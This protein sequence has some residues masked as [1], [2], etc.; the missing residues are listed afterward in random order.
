MFQV[1]GVHLPDLSSVVSE[2]NEAQEIRNAI[3]HRHGVI[4]DDDVVRVPSLVPTDGSRVRI[5]Q[6]Q[7]DRYKSA[8]CRFSEA[9]MGALINS[10]RAPGKAWKAL[11]V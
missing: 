4:T 8:L 7:F 6:Q 1:V 9:L 11:R 5:G 10:R 3:M 2:L